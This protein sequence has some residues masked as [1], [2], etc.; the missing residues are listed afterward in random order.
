MAILILIFSFTEF[1]HKRASPTWKKE[2]N[3]LKKLVSSLENVSYF[4][5]HNM[6]KEEVFS[7]LNTMDMTPYHCLLC[8][9]A[10]HGSCLNGTLTLEACNREMFLSEIVEILTSNMKESK[11]SIPCIMLIQACRSGSKDDDSSGSL[12]A[13]FCDLQEWFPRNFLI[14]YSCRLSKLTEIPV[15]TQFYTQYPC[16]LITNFCESFPSGSVTI[17]NWIS[18]AI[19]HEYEV[20]HDS[21]LIKNNICFV[22]R[23]EEDIMFHMKGETL[24]YISNT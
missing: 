18:K 23:L 17:I 4:L 19:Y 10:T 11:K 2:M 15:E 14:C 16:T 21:S 8:V 3:S 13:E 6:T 7:I 22:S 1:R 5:Y 9:F 24:Q 12:Q 20:Q